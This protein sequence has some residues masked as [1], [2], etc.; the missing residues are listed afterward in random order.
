MGLDQSSTQK[1]TNA[2]GPAILAALVSLVSKSQGAIKLNDLVAK[3][4]PGVLSNLGKVIGESAQKAFIDNGANGLTSLL[5][6]TTA[7][8]I[9]NAVGHYA[10][11]GGGNSK[12]LFG[13]VGSA[14]LGVLGQVQRDGGRDA[15]GLAMLLVSQKD[16]IRAALPLGFS[17]YLDQ[18]VVSLADVTPSTTKFAAQTPYRS[19]PP[20]GLGC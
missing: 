4:E 14:V 18:A 16:V 20:S 7:S 15:S 11:I 10:G 3:Q 9:T 8:A 13:L 19:T 12:S 5:G 1:A 6:G 2:A 17:K